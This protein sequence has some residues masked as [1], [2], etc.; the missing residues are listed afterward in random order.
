VGQPRPAR[1]QFAEDVFVDGKRCPVAAT[2]RADRAADKAVR[3]RC[4]WA[5]LQAYLRTA[6][7]RGSLVPVV[8]FTNRFK[9]LP[10]GSDI[11][12][13]GGEAGGG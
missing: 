3:L 2:C 13:A 1:G 4:A 10:A 9:W 5:Q 12:D 11:P 8:P 6:R 7:G